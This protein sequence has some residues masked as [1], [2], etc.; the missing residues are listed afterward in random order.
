M[1]AKK[2]GKENKRRKTNKR[3][4]NHL[5]ACETD[6]LKAFEDIHEAPTRRNA[7]RIPR[8][9]AGGAVHGPINRK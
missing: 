4:I 7:R 3:W 9:L 5:L 2:K 8:R 6:F 1:H